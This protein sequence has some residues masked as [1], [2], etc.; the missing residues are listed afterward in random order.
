[1]QDHLKVCTEKEAV[2]ILI[3]GLITDVHTHIQTHTDT[4]IR[5]QTKWW[6]AVAM[7][8]ICICCVLGGDT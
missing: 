2:L 3:I 1:M 5:G 8:M 7:I 6:C 4:L